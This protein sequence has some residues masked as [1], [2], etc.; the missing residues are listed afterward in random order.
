M[1]K[2]FFYQVGTVQHEYD[3][4]S[5]TEKLALLFRSPHNAFCCKWQRTAICRMLNS[6]QLT[7]TLGSTCAATVAQHNIPQAC[8]T[9]SFPHAAPHGLFLF[10]WTKNALK[11]AK[12]EDVEMIQL[13]WCSNFYYRFTEHIGHAS[14]SGRESGMSLSKQNGLVSK[15]ISL[16]LSKFSIVSFTASIQILFIRPHTSASTSLPSFKCLSLAVKW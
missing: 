7:S 2:P 15:G 10:P 6:S 9:V 1:S 5:K 4:Q 13:M 11:D 16:P 3:P 12:F 8:K 14:S